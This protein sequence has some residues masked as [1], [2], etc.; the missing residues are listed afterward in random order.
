MSVPSE[1]NEGRF[2]RL[3]AEG[4]RRMWRGART[5]IAILFVLLLVLLLFGGDFGL[6]SLYR[7][8]RFEKRIEEEIGAAQ[9]RQDSLKQ[10]MLKLK[11]D[12]AFKERLAREKLRM[13]KDGE[14]IYRFDD[15]KGK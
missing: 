8:R 13:I 6:I 2:L 4:R 14:V 15:K 7:Y 1:Q 12:D 9:A 11:S 5:A 10:V 3:D